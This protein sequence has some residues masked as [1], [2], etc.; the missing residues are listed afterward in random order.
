[1]KRTNNIFASVGL[2]VGAIFGALGSIFV[3]PVELQIILY[4]ISS[5]G[6]TAASVLLAIKFIRENND[7]LATGF[8][9]FAIGEAIMTVGMSSG[10]VGGQ[11]SF[12]AGMALYVPGLLFISIPKGF[13]IWTR[14]TGMAATIPFT[15][16]A[17]RIFLGDEVL[18]TSA[19][20]GIGY[21]LLI[22]TI[23]G[24]VFT[25][26]KEKPNQDHN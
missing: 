24:W 16:A 22:L 3:N 11:P 4:E 25:L 20:P 10:P 23:I 21:G 14:I 12:G 7:L 2:L 26:V 17:V 8:L 1:M 9:I 18:S 6:L 5:I 13:P 19:M 15:I